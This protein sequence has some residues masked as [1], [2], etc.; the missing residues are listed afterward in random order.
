LSPARKSD[1]IVSWVS[2]AGPRVAKI[3]ALLI[4]YYFATEFR[5]NIRLAKENLTVNQ[6]KE[7]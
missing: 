6:H 5:E 2:E 7:A 4:D 3:F 1:S